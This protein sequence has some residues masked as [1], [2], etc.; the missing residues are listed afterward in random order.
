MI[1][2][3]IRPIFSAR[4]H[5]PNEFDYTELLQTHKHTVAHLPPVGR[6]MN[7]NSARKSKRG[8]FENKFRVNS[9]TMRLYLF[10]LLFVN[11]PNARFDHVLPSGQEAEI[12][13]ITIIIWSFEMTPWAYTNP[14]KSA[15]VRAVATKTPLENACL[16][17]DSRVDKGRTPTLAFQTN[18]K[19]SSHEAHVTNASFACVPLRS[20]ASQWHRFSRYSNEFD[21]RVWNFPFHPAIPLKFH[22]IFENNSRRKRAVIENWTQLSG[23]PWK[24]FFIFVCFDGQSQSAGRRTKCLFSYEKKIVS[25]ELNEI[26]PR[27][28][29]WDTHGQLFLFHSLGVA[30]ARVSPK[31]FSWNAH[32]HVR[33]PLDCT[34][35]THS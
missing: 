4:T 3:S 21:T 6:F 5:T 22:S 11:R 30:R 28:G 10:E 31:Q 19:V 9:P 35:A 16:Q 20:E 32:T 17:Y 1:E 33:R 34:R 14:T 24:W 12:N 29:R 8:E 27:D 13:S 15:W 23:E 26:Q 2:S 18:T 7:N 25:V